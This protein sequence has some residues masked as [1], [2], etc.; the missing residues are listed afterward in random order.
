MGTLQC[1]GRGSG[2]KSENHIPGLQ[3]GDIFFLE[4]RNQGTMLGN[5]N[6]TQRSLMT[7]LKANSISCG[8]NGIWT[9]FDLIIYR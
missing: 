8:R 5:F 2:K 9:L 6:F 3:M 4:G 1:E 7:L